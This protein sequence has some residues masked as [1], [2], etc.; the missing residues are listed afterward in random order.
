M[1]LPWNH[2]SD[3]HSIKIY[4]VLLLSIL[5]WNSRRCTCH[6]G[7]QGDLERLL[8]PSIFRQEKCRMLQGAWLDRKLLGWSRLGKWV[9]HRFCNRLKR[10][11]G[12]VETSQIRLFQWRPTKLLQVCT[13][14]WGVLRHGV[15]GFL[16]MS[17]LAWW[18]FT[19]IVQIT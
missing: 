16:A 1:F 3:K 11:L 13:R 5:S 12:S 18:L 10:K 9:V 19:N 14:P 2:Q 17:R 6:F 4:H 15:S 8:R 7:T